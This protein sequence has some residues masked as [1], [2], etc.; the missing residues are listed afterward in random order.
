MSTEL[1]IAS[2]YKDE[3]GAVDVIGLFICHALR[4][5]AVHATTLDHL[6][7]GMFATPGRTL[8]FT[9]PMDPVIY[10]AKQRSNHLNISVD[11]DMKAHRL[12][13]DLKHASNLAG[14]VADIASHDIRRGSAQELSRL[15]SIRLLQAS[16]MLAEL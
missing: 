2:L 11:S 8:R 16:K 12:N 13:K 14:I 9:R 10:A 1:E 6:V 3:F 15:P 5:G 7:C 4:M